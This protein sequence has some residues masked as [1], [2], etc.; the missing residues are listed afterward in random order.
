MID[1]A[2][3][4]LGSNVGDRRTH[5]ARA[6]TAIAAFPHCR[7]LAATAIEETAPLGPVD[8]GPF[9]NQMIAVETALTPH[10]LLVHLQDVERQE[11][12]TRGVRWGP[13]TLDLDIVW[14]DHQAVDDGVLRVPHPEIAH[15]DFWR[16]E[17][18]ELRGTE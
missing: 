15:R 17:L 7:I 14:F 11:G 3:V 8:Q 13:R 5:L 9:L 1:V 12:R 10:A 4:A 16:R 6:R 2:Y 18:A